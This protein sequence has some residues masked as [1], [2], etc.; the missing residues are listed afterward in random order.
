MPATIHVNGHG[1]SSVF[2]EFDAPGGTGNKVPPIGPVTFSSSD[3]TVATVDGNGNIAAIA[4]GGPVTITATDTGT[5]IPSI[6]ATDTVTVTAAVA[7]SATL[8]VTANP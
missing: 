5:P 4:P 1:A 7:V 8:A 2:T 6:M 3:T